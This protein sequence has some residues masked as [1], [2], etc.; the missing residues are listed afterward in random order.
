MTGEK[1]FTL[2]EVIIAAL[3]IT[4]AVMGVLDLFVHAA[5]FTT[6]SEQLVKAVNLGQGKLEELKY[7]NFDMVASQ[8]Q[9]QFAENPDFSYSVDVVPSAYGYDLKTVT[10]KVFYMDAGQDKTI[11]LAMERAKR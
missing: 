2:I 3:V 10:V 4:I 11:S 6:S 7:T 1:G 5:R 8:G 9:A